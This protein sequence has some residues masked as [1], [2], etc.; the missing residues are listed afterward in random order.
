M[1]GWLAQQPR[2]GSAQTTGPRYFVPAPPNLDG[3]RL[4][5]GE[6]YFAVKGRSLHG[7]IWTDGDT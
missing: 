4:K 3:S 1:V 7:K 2:S 6:L 5:K